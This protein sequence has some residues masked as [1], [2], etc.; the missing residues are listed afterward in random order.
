MMKSGLIDTKPIYELSAEEGRR[1]DASNL[2]PFNR[3][4]APVAKKSRTRFRGPAGYIPVIVYTPKGIGPFPVIVYYHGGGWV[5]G[6]LETADEPA[7][8]L[9]NR[10]G[11]VVVSVGYRLAPE[12]RFPA[13]PE[14]CYAAAVWA[15]ANARR[16]GGDPERL[17]VEGDSAGGNL[18]AVVCLMARDRGGPPIVLQLLVYPAVDNTAKSPKKFGEAEAATREW[19][20]SKYFA[21]PSDRSKPLASPLL[22]DLHGLPKAAIVTG[23]YDPL[24]AQCN[25]FASKLR[26]SGVP[27]VKREFQGMPHAFWDLPGYFDAGREAAR[28]LGLQVRSLRAP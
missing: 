13:A 10:A 20:L 17:V 3:K 2:R 14:D 1:L 12:H 9:C 26:S 7:S 6:S 5:I 8:M 16:L 11:A 28:W 23:Q 19:F 21:G 27:V 25:Q 18:A 24:T 22:A 4:P 15:H